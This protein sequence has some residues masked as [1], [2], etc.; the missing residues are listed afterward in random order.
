VFLPGL[1][2]D[3][4]PPIFAS[5][6]AG[7]VDM[8]PHVWPSD[9]LCHNI[10]VCHKTCQDSHQVERFSVLQAGGMLHYFS[11]TFVGFGGGKSGCLCQMVWFTI[12]GNT[13]QRSLQVMK[14][15]GEYIYVL[16]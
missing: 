12:L 16:L 6:V 13:D 14:E 2:S 15:D 10:S 8:H 7:T 1:S 4:Y 11:L 5:G 9:S 3:L